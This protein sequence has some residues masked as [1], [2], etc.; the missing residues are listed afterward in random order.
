M[1]GKFGE[2]QLWLWP[3]NTVEIGAGKA[4]EHH[5]IWHLC[6]HSLLQ[7]LFNRK[8]QLVS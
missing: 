8:M 1:V 5:G 6:V 4:A 2:N 7:D 3:F